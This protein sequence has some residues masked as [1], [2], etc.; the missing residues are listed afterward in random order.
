MTRSKLKA[1]KSNKGG[2]GA[3][4]ALTEILLVLILPV[5][6]QTWKIKVQHERTYES[7]VLQSFGSFVPVVLTQ[8][9]V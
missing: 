1:T 6:V 9:V 8:S 4:Q 5:G 2:L 3:G 7:S